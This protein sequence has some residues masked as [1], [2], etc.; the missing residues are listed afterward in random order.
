MEQNENIIRS[1]IRK[2]CLDALRAAEFLQLIDTQNFI[3]IVS[4]LLAA[5]FSKGHKLIIAGNGGSLC[6]AMHVAEEFTGYFRSKRRALP[7]IALA[8]P[9][10][11]TCV[12]NDSSFNDIFARGIEAHGVSGDVF[13]GLS[14]S[15]NSENIK[16]AIIEARARGLRT[17][18]FLGK[19]GGLIKGLA[20]HESIVS[21]FSYSDRV[22]EVHMT[23]LHIIIQAVEMQ[24]FSSLEPS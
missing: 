9:G 13:I 8:D 21:G 20:D 24:L 19:T 12:G 14:T 22:Q 10:H 4:E 3:F 7:A 18:T 23:M 5:Q 6:D 1:E 15:G 2:E 16:R 11:I 17:I